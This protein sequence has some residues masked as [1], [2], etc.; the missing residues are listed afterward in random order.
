MLAAQ[1]PVASYSTTT[2]V[3]T[4]TCTGVG[5]NFVDNSYTG[6]TGSAS[7]AGSSL[8]GGSGLLTDGVIAALDYNADKVS[9]L[10]AIIFFRLDSEIVAFDSGHTLAGTQLVAPPTPTRLS[11]S[12]SA[13]IR[14]SRRFGCRDAIF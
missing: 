14:P 1:V 11:L 6:G 3:L 9:L 12:R 10:C 4:S 13:T 8:A 7:T 5:N 2:G